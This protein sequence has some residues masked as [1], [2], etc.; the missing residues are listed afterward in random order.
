[1]TAT[2]SPDEY[3][4]DIQ[5]AVALWRNTSNSNGDRACARLFLAEHG[6]FTVIQANHLIKKVRAGD[7]P[8]RDPFAHAAWDQARRELPHGTYTAI[9]QRTA[10]ILEERAKKAVA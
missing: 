10:D 7:I 1:M 9:A 6:V 5:D 4:L 3:C 8:D 2:I